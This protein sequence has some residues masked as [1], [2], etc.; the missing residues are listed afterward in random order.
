[1]MSESWVP[2]DHGSD[3]GGLGRTVARGL[4]WTIVDTWGRQLLNLAIFVVLARLLVP[5]DFGLVAL[6]TVFVGFAQVV[7]DQGLG[8]A[9]IQRRSVTRPQM[10]TAFWVAMGTGTALTLLGVLVAVPLAAFLGEPALGPILQVLALTFILSALSSI[11]MA[12]LRREMA[13]RSLAIRA[14]VAATV[15]GLVGIIMALLGFGAWAL[16]GQQV[17]AAA[18]SVVVLW[19]MIPWRPSLRFSGADFR[20]LFGY[21]AHVLGSDVLNYLS[22]NVD[23][24]LIG[25]FLGPVPLGIYAIAYRIL[26]ISQSVLVNVARRIAFP[27]LASLQHDADRLQRAYFRLTRVASVVILPGYVGLAIVAGDLTPL[28]F[29]DQWVESGPVAMILFLIGPVLTVQAFSGALLNAV[30]RPD[31]V[32]RFRLITAAVNV[33]GFILAVRFGIV[34]VA[35]AFVIRGYLLL[36]LNLAWTRR[37]AG[38]PISAYL[39]QLAGVAVATAT[40]AAAMLL[41]R[42]LLPPDAA[43]AAVTAG[44]ALVGLLT[45][46]ATIAFV[47]RGLL[48][49]LRAVTDDVTRGS[50]RRRRRGRRDGESVMR[51]VSAP[52]D[53]E[54]I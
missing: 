4:T 2:T 51:S 33:V 27:A 22:R 37:Y 19:P 43:P 39:G 10:D 38:I 6:A 11:Q 26:T 40:M 34:A 12:L 42:P 44:Q 54:S 28:L 29:G 1:M 24:L 48:R 5:A 9:L 25:V 20:S 17:A 18:I 15:G 36:P 8:D 3:R 7:V 49:E 53:S 45:F 31:V 30:G 41:V 14:I 13:F 23:N 32:F 16:V 47:E 35:A 46:A 50:T 52:D 21:G